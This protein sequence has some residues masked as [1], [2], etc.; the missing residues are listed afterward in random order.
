MLK[1]LGSVVLISFSLSLSGCSSTPKLKRLE[2]AQMPMSGLF[3]DY[4]LLSDDPH[5]EG[6]G[7]N[8]TAGKLEGGGIVDI[9][10]RKGE[11]FAI[12]GIDPGAYYIKS[13]YCHSNAQYETTDRVTDFIIQNGKISYFGPVRYHVGY[14]VWKFT[15]TGDENIGLSQVQSSISEADQKRFVD[16]LTLRPLAFPVSK[17]RPKKYFTHTLN[18]KTIEPVLDCIANNEILSFNSRFGF[19]KFEVEYANGKSK[20][21]SR[22]YDTHSSPENLK[23]C[24][25]NVLSKSTVDTSTNRAMV[26][27]KGATESTARN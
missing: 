21:V 5:I 8:I 26:E 1:I 14:K 10:I 24:I 15:W 23:T 20:N 7:C 19:T 16:A 22:T 12:F 3:L 27:L 2:I 18:D 11:S 9:P 17:T 4:T 6:S 25:E 13:V